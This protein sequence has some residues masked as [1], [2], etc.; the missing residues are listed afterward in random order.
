MEGCRT[1]SLK[2]MDVA[3]L[4]PFISMSPVCTKIILGTTLITSLSAHPC[5]HN[6]EPDSC[7][8]T[9]APHLHKL[10]LSCIE[11]PAASQETDLSPAVGTT[12]S[13]QQLLPYCTRHVYTGARRRGAS[14]LQGKEA[15]VSKEGL[16][17][18]QGQR[19]ECCVLIKWSV[20]LSIKKGGEGRESEKENNSSL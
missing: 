1:D 15:H 13:Q 10:V 8:K 9:T 6:S 20:I 3:N 7:E 16:K 11:N 4:S 19:R 12:P 5:T 18:H 14:I 17:W 2:S